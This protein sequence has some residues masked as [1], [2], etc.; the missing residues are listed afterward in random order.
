[1]PITKAYALVPFFVLL[2]IKDWSR[3]PLS[4]PGSYLESF[5]QRSSDIEV[6]GMGLE[7]GMVMEDTL[8]HL[9]DF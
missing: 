9:S 8:S 5:S 4:N 7:L 1:M 6:F 3:S 2:G